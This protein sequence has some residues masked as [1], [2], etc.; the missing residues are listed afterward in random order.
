MFI[1]F[2]CILCVFLLHFKEFFVHFH[3]FLF[4]VFC[5]LSLQAMALKKYYVVGQ[6]SAGGE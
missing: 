3:V 6:I 5:A 2:S 1:H 4:V